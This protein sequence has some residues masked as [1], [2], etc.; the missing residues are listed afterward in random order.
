MISHRSLYE[1][2]KANLISDESYEVLDNE[3]IEPIQDTGNNVLSIYNSLSSNGFFFIFKFIFK[4][5]LSKYVLI[6]ILNATLL[7][8]S[9]YFSKKTV[10][11]RRNSVRWQ[12]VKQQLLARK[13]ELLRTINDNQLPED[14]PE[15]FPS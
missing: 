2:S 9:T 12:L 14:S 8:K 7:S 11:F 3:R 6:C 10:D 13:M 15:T 4:Y 5:C 1:V